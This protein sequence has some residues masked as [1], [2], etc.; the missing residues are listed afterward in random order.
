MPRAKSGINFFFAPPLV[1]PGTLLN[2]NIP[3]KILSIPM[4]NNTI[5][6]TVTITLAEN[7]GNPNNN[8]TEDNMSEINP[9]PICIARNQLGV[10]YLSK[11]R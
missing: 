9:D 5:E 4:D 10:L 11:A 1:G 6:S 2:T 8:T 3:N 7:A